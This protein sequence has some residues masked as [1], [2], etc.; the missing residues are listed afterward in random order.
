MSS[1]AG[2]AAGLVGVTL[3]FP[4]VYFWGAG[5]QLYMVAN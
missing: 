3:T 2:G 1:C 4:F 5:C